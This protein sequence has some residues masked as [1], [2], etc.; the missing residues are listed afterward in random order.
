[1][2]FRI[3]IGKKLSS[4]LVEL[5]ERRTRQSVDVAVAEAAAAV[6]ARINEVR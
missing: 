3:V 5:V 1:V 4:G 2:P 6:A